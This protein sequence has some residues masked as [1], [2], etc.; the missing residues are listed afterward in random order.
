MIR[1]V[2]LFAHGTIRVHKIIWIRQLWGVIRNWLVSNLE[3]KADY[4]SGQMTSSQA[5]DA[6]WAVT[7]GILL[8]PVR[9]LY[10]LL[11][12]RLSYN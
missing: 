7:S 12:K 3:Q 1:R 5:L 8:V 11:K 2:T 10:Q 9:N 6:H 4:I